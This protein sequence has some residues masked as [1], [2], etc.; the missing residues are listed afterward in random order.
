MSSETPLLKLL[1]C[2]TVP[3]QIELAALAKTTR[4]YLYQMAAC[5]RC[6]FGAA[7]VQRISK[8]A[9]EMHV[10]SLGRIPKISAEEIATMCSVKQ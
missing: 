8:A 4:N 1:R 2:C 9:T 3:E 5:H 7:L 10:R 6:E